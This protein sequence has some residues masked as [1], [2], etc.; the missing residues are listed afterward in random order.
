MSY[1]TRTH[2]RKL[3]LQSSTLPFLKS[4]QNNEVAPNAGH[5]SIGDNVPGTFSGIYIQPCEQPYTT[6]GRLPNLPARHE[7]GGSR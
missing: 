6:S 7:D 5:R 4:C 3:S 1:L 2:L